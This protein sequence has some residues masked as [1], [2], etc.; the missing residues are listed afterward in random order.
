MKHLLRYILTRL[1]LTI[2]M[3]F[4][5]LTVVFFVL[6]IM[7]GDPVSSMLGGHAPE[8]VIQKKQEEL[9]L[10]RPLIVQ[11][12]EY[13]WQICRLDLGESMI[14]K[15]RVTQPIK[16]KLPATLELTITGALI[17]LFFG[18]F[19]GA[20][21]ADKRRTARDYS[22]RLYGIVIYCIPVYWLGLMFQLIFGVWLDVLPIAGRT[23]PRVFASTFEKTGFYVIDT[24][25]VKDFAAFGDVLVHLILP[26][27]TLGLVVSGIFVRLTR[28]NM[29]DVLKAD[30]IVAARARGIPNKKVVYRHGLKNALVPILTML[31][32]QFALLMAGAVLT[33]TTFSWPGMGRL[34]LERIYARDYP[35]IQGIIIM[36]ALV[37]A[38]ASLIVDVMYALIDPRVRY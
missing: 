5:M 18:V 26:S 36:F 21:A 3:V 34:L 16:E 10:N 17:T 35:T 31:G 4:I 14:F 24:L 7:P 13:L 19:L 22:I 23:G 29:L 25:M 2:P 33:E 1:L 20:Y 28:A 12:A 37:V 32:L 11:Y 9:G 6:R 38:F 15:Q 27:V 30:Y 8:K